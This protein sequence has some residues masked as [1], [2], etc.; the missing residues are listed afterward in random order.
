MLVG[1]RVL[2]AD[3]EIRLRFHLAHRHCP[4][5]RHILPLLC[6]SVTAA[7]FLALVAMHFD[8]D[9]KKQVADSD[10]SA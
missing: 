8:W 10:A 2:L 4:P 5:E 7:C 3:W 6:S 9:E 1:G